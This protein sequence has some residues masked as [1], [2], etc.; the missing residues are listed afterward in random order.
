MTVTV[1][2]GAIV[3]VFGIQ[4]QQKPMYMSNVLNKRKIKDFPLIKDKKA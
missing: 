1:S 4:Q 3:A 2:V